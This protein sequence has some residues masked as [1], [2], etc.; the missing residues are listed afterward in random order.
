M[1]LL[2]FYF[3][4]FHQIPENDSWWGEG[5]DD[6]RLVKAASSCG[7]GHYQPRVPLADNY[8]DLSKAEAVAQQ[9][10]WAEDYGLDGFNFYHYWFDGKLLLSDPLRHFYENKNHNLEYCITWANETWTRQWIG[11]PEVL[12]QQSSSPDRK[13]WQQHYDYLDTYFQDPRYRRMQGK[14]VLC[15]YRPEILP[16]LDEYMAF[17]DEQAK[18]HGHEGIFWIGFESYE[19]AN[20]EEIFK[21]FDASLRFQ[22]RAFFNAKAKQGSALKSWLEPI[23]RSLPERLQRPISRLKYRL[24][25][26][27]TFDYK[28]LWQNVLA[29]SAE[30]ATNCYQSVIVDW[31]NT[32]R[33]GLKS[34]YFSGASPE[35]FKD[36]LSQLVASESKR[37]V[38]TIFINAW[39]E[40]SEGAYLEPDTRHQFSYLEAIKAIKAEL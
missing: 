16:F 35:A 27:Q 3:P 20:K 4:Q 23:L 24:D 36:G 22:P 15:L 40:W 33:Y 29:D 28:E 26:Q 32:P 1:K 9:I 10:R 38:D 5:F 14:P 34:K 2:A 6:W 12:I 8:Y 17:F 7:A 37:G 13:L 30:Q 39:N 25:R 31:D 18:L 11:D 21:G 19:L